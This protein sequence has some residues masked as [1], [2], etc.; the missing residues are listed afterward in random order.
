MSFVKDPDATFR[1][2]SK[3]KAASSHP[4]IIKLTPNVT[5]ITVIAKAAQDAGADGLSLINTLTGMA[6]D[7]E[8]RRPVL[9]NI[10]GGLSGPCIK[11][12]ALWNVFR[13]ARA[14][15]IPIIG[16]GG[17]TN[18]RD[19]LEFLIAGARAIAIGSAN[20]ID[21]GISLKIL[22]GISSYLKKNRI[23]DINEIIGS[24]K[25]LQEKQE[26]DYS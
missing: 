10:S 16:M 6:I 23:K 14:V 8:S 24:L 2:D 12:V 17:I 25:T 19:A 20:F 22:G 4:L 1:I 18:F 3:I 26:E 7:L 5:D 9:G 21:P 13:V 11:P 15:K